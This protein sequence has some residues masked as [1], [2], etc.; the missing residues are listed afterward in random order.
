MY[1]TEENKKK[2]NRKRKKNPHRDRQMTL[3]IP[4]GKKECSFMQD[5][6]DLKYFLKDVSKPHYINLH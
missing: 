1:C 2:E 6:F 3:L 4:E 5:I